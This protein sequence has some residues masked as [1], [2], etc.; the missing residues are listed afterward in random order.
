MLSQNLKKFKYLIAF[1][2]SALIVGVLFVSFPEGAFSQSVSELRNQIQDKNEAIRAI[3]REI[4]QYEAELQEIGAEKD[5]LK[6]AIRALDLSR[7][8][9]SADIRATEQKIGATNL[10]I[11]RLN[12]D[13]EDTERRIEQNNEAIGEA[14]R[15]MNENDSI[16]MIES[17]LSEDSLS[18]FWNTIDALERVQVSLK[19]DLERLKKAKEELT[20]A[21]AEL[22]VRKEDLSNYNTDLSA[23]KNVLDDNKAEK[24]RLLKATASEE[25]QYQAILEEKKAEKAAFE[26]EIFQI[27]SQLQFILDPSKLPSA[28]SGVLSWPLDNV[29]VTQ[30]FGRTSSSGRLYSSGTHN[31]VDF[32]ASVGTRV[33][34]SLSG[35]VLAVNHQ[36]ATLCQYGKWVLIRHNNG[37]TT[38]Y[39]HLSSVNVSTGQAVSTGDIVGYSGNT[40]YSLGPHLHFTV[41]ASD[42]VKFKEYTCN[43][44][45]TLTIPVSAPNGYLD[46]MIYL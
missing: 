37:L 19:G 44:G 13:I 43:S 3:E 22:Q 14:I 33:K 18:G 9:L 7:Q 4:A 31:G 45:A 28:G 8:K 32:R 17:V 21:R 39:A 16:S 46:P 2:F 26:R 41:Y 25:A 42:A 11:N 29:F 10:N 5:T 35:E 12:I 27:E 24:D 1:I 20:L 30:E 38:L 6:S 23:K 40:G 34:A 15:R 36:V